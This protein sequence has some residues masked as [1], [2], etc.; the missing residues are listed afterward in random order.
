MSNSFISYVTYRPSGEIVS[1][2]VCER[3]TI[4]NTTPQGCRFLE[5]DRQWMPNDYY[6]VESEVV[7]K[8]EFDV[9][10][11]GQT[12]AGIPEGTTVQFEGES[13]VV[14]DGEIEFSFTMPGTFDIKLS[15][16]PYMPKTVKVTL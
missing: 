3:S 9:Q 15:R 11:V 12:I 1:T 16:F 14:D 8:L 13:W 5:T 4:I 2:G 10:V 7:P 6:V